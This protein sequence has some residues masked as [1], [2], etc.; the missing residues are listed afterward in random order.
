MLNIQKEFSNDFSGNRLLRSIVLKSG[1]TYVLHNDIIVDFENLF[2]TEEEISKDPFLRYGFF[3]A[4]IM[5][6]K[7]IVLKMNHHSMTMSPRMK[8]ALRFFSLIE[9]NN[10]PF[11]LTDG[12]PLCD[13]SKQTCD[14]QSGRNICILSGLFQKSSHSCIHGNNN[15]H[16]KIRNCQFRDFEV[17]AIML[18]GFHNITISNC[19]IIGETNRNDNVFQSSVPFNSKWSA[20]LQL[21]YQSSLIYNVPSFLTKPLNEKVSFLLENEEIPQLFINKTG[22]IEGTIYGILLN[23][24]G[25]AIRSH[26]SADQ[27]IELYS[28]QAKIHNVKIQ[29]IKGGSKESIAT[30]YNGRVIRDISGHFIDLYK[31]LQTG[32]M[33]MLTFYQLLVA[34]KKQNQPSKT[35]L[36]VPDS[37]RTW[38]ESNFENRFQSLELLWKNKMEISLDENEIKSLSSLAEKEFVWLRGGDG[39]FHVNKGNI[40]LKLDGVHHTTISDLTIENVSNEG[41]PLKQLEHKNV[42]FVHSN[43]EDFNSYTGNDSYGI[44]VNNCKHL[45][46][47]NLSFHPILSTSG[48]A[49]GL[50]IM[51]QTKDFQIQNIKSE[52]EDS[53][54]KRKDGSLPLDISSNYSS[55]IIQKSCSNFIIKD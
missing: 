45:D 4:I 10:S 12:L 51:N 50:F 1:K 14:W 49:F 9:L 55:I 2:P 15:K 18:N 46:M 36:F 47:K 54:K 27:S 53:S 13:T 29:N 22:F 38:F 39:M 5:S 20:F 35:T 32:K 30:T 44:V 19:Q 33:D 25:V 7:D 24:Q 34:L 40:A 17:G 26:G 23:R 42:K 21:A 6:G 16:I 37:L 8:K 48:R 43:T 52:K 41:Q 11:P 28:S 3:A 31:I